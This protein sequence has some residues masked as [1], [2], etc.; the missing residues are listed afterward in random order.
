MYVYLIIIYTY[1][2]RVWKFAALAHS[3][4]P[5][6]SRSANNYS[7]NIFVLHF[8]LHFIVQLKKLVL[9]F[10]VSAAHSRFNVNVISRQLQAMFLLASY[11]SARKWWIWDRIEASLGFTQVDSPASYTCPDNR[12]Q[13][14][15]IPV[16]YL[17][18]RQK[19]P[20][21]CNPPTARAA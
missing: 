19:R 11:M 3:S 8:S 13:C 10:Q 2:S 17:T 20:M 7:S 6:I 5:T 21:Q 18:Q 15:C 14:A 9:V 12:K 1:I 4:E 16:T